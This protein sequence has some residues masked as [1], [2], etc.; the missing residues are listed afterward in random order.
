MDRKELFKIILMESFER[1]LPYGVEREYNIPLNLNH[2]AVSIV[3]PRRS[4]KTFLIFQ[5]INKIS[6]DVPRDRILYVNLEDDRILPL[7]ENDLSLMLDAYYELF[8]ENA[9]EELY[10]FLDEVQNAPGW[11]AFVRRSLDRGLRVFVTGSSSKLLSREIATSLRGRSITFEIQPFSFREF[12]RAKGIVE[13]RAVY[14]SE[15]FKI[16]ALFHEYL[17]W[18]GFPEVV[19]MDD[20]FLKLRTLQEY[21]EVM[22][23]K[24]I[25]ERYNVKKFHVLRHLLKF[26]ASNVSR[27]FSASSYYKFAKQELNVRKEDILHFTSYIEDAKMFFFLPIFSYSLKAQ[28]RNPRKVYCVDTGLRNANTF[29]V[30]E[31]YGYL[32][33]NIVFLELRSRLLRNPSLELYYWREPRTQIEVDFVVKNGSNIQE[34]IQVSWDIEESMDRGVRGM[35]RALDAFSMKEGVILTRDYEDIKKMDG[36]KI[37]FKPIWK[38]LLG[39]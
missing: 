38:W 36:K 15:R 22:F 13:D 11:E 19:L 3:G 10:L 18:G 17:K 35:V 39:Q 31:D 14:T 16:K 20:E 23:Y 9:N 6:N 4:G 21:F 33:E 7:R 24:D 29:L 28:L 34:L 27:Y 25:V 1:E 12:L 37:I 2:K 26:L 30:S 32:A 8:P 5:L